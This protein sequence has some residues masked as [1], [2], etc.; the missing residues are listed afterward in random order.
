MLNTN[1]KVVT[2]ASVNGQRGEHRSDNL[3]FAF[4]LG[5]P[6]EASEQVAINNLR[7][8]VKYLSNILKQNK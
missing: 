2:D 7:G 1:Q 4:D 3:Y 6:I 8:F 5:R